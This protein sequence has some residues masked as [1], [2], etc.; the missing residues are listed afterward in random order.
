MYREGS[1]KGILAI[2]IGLFAVVAGCYWHRT[3][4]LL[5]FLWNLVVIDSRPFWLD[6]ARHLH[7]AQ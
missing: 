2:F 1:G 5:K 7:F 4:F 3:L 6:L